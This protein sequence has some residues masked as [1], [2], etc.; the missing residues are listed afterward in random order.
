M[1]GQRF[2]NKLNIKKKKKKNN[3]N[4]LRRLNQIEG[5]SSAI[6]YPR[7]CNIKMTKNINQVTGSSFHYED[8]DWGG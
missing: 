1:P 6:S 2:I 7:W 3:F 8:P 4:N 5:T